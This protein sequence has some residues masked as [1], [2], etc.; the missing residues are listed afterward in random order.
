MMKDILKKV[1][2]FLMLPGVLDA[3]FVC[4]MY[5]LPSFYS[6]TVEYLS[7][8]FGMDFSLAPQ[9]FVMVFF[10][11]SVWSVLYVIGSWWDFLF[12][13]ALKI[14]SFFKRLFHR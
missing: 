14:S 13:L 11:L 10:L 9:G 12:P 6:D 4:F 5:S 3:L 1:F 7:D 8:S 2:R